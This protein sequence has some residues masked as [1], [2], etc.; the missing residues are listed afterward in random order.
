MKTAYA[1]LVGL[2]ALTQS[3]ILSAQSKSLFDSSF[4]QNALIW[5]LTVKIRLF[6]KDKVEFGPFRVTKAKLNGSGDHRKGIFAGSLIGYAKVEAYTA[7]EI[8]VSDGK[9]TCGADL[10]FDLK[11]KE[12]SLFLLDVTYKEKQS[13][14]VLLWSYSV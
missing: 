9:D 8:E 11:R 7:W 4:T 10:M 14:Y 2:L 5:P 13:F 1:A 6:K 12:L 3:F